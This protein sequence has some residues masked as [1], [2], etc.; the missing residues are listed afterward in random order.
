MEDYFKSLGC[1]YVLVDVFA[2]NENGIKFYN[3]NK[4]HNRMHTM[5]KKLDDNN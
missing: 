4:Y 1:E 2:Y 3:K 5:I